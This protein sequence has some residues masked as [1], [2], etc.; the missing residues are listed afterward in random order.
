[1]LLTALLLLVFLACVGFGFRNGMWSN[2]IRLVNVITAAL[3]ATNCFEPLADWLQGFAG[4]YQ[5][6]A[7][8]VALWAVFVAA[9]GGLNLATD[10]VSKVRVRFA[11]IVDRVG[12]VFFSAWVGWVMVGFTLF[13][14]HAAPLPREFLFGN[15]QAEQPMFLGMAPDRQWLAFVHKLSRGPLCRS[16]TTDQWRRE[17]TVFDPRGEFMIKY[18]SRRSALEQHAEKTGTVRTQ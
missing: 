18:A 5:Y 12:S 11:T 14:L 13:T 6:F 2:A 16:A 3:V 9:L 4:S 8:I 1:M 15:F 17:A 10:A 7:D